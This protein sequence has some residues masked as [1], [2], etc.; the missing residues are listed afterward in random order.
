MS[1]TIKAGSTAKLDCAATGDPQPQIA[2]QKD[3]G[4][5][6]PAALERRMHYMPLDVSFYISDAKISDQGIY[7]CTA[8]N[9]VGIITTNA[10]LTI[11]GE[12]L[13]LKNIIKI[14]II[15]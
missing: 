2:W 13:G 6:F 3:G 10:T 7:T 1:L 8:E 9:S 5:D 4:H 14:F 15:F 12:F 11:N